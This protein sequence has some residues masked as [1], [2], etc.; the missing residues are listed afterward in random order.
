MF[1]KYRNT[2]SIISLKKA[3]KEIL[4]LRNELE[5]TPIK[6]ENMVELRE[7]MKEKLMDILS[8][9]ESVRHIPSDIEQLCQSIFEHYDKRKFI[10]ESDPIWNKMTEQIRSHNPQFYKYIEILSLG[11]LNEGDLKILELIRCGITPTQISNIL[12]KEKGT[13]SSRRTSMSK[14]MFDKSVGNTEFDFII[15]SL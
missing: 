10:P 7:R 1:M 15:R 2:R 14:R 9:T 6:K 8:H 3:Q 4:K 5:N 13:I 11:K 12:G